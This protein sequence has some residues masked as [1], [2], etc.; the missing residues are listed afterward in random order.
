MA[1][2]SRSVGQHHGDL[3]RAVIDATL[4][5]LREGHL[6]PSLRQAARRSGVSP[7]APY[8]HFR[9][10]QGLMVAVQRWT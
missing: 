5:L 2:T 10:R 8:H 3:R 4:S 7:A 1:P 9:S 6:A